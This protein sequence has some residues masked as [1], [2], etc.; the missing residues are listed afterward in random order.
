MPSAIRS[1]P[2]S[3]SASRITA[4]AGVARLGQ[5]L[6]PERVDADEGD[7]GVEQHD[8]ADAEQQAA[9]EVAARD[10]ASRRRRSSRSAS[11]HK[12]T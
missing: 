1:A 11:R 9:G 4:E 10:R 6:R 3:P 5:P 8:A 2:R 12:R 7:G